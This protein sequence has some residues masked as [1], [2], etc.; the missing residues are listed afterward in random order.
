M[1]TY[2]HAYT[3]AKIYTCTSMYN[4]Y[5]E[6]NLDIY[7]TCMYINTYT[8]IYIIH[9]GSDARN[10]FAS[11]YTYKPIYLCLKTCIYVHVYTCMYSPQCT[12]ICM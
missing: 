3:H 2:V 5:F 1:Y 12:Y 4:Y 6:G 7:S 11:L 8:C 10:K 9:Y